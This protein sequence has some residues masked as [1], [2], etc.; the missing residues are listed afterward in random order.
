MLVLSIAIKRHKRYGLFPKYTNVR[1][2]IISVTSPKSLADVADTAT[3]AD[4]DAE[5]A[6]SSIAAAA[7]KYESEHSPPKNNLAEI[8]VMTG[9]EDE[10]NVIQV[11]MKNCEYVICI[12][13]PF[14]FY[15]SKFNGYT[16]FVETFFY[17]GKENLT[18]SLGQ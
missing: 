8:H 10:R 15:T 13:R 5:T 17:L 1:Y 14:L 6:T 11:R 2:F 3:K 12:N 18:L 9:E 7:Q 4:S 16:S